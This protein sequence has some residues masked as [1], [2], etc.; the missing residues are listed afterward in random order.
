MGD[1]RTMLFNVTLPSP[2]VLASGPLSYDAHGRWTANRAGAGAIVTKTLRLER[3][4][5]PTP[6]RVVPRSSNLRPW[7]FNSGRSIRGRRCR[8]LL[9]MRII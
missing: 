6:H 4:I 1:L 5:N 3:A 8:Q 9:R 7:L 2:F